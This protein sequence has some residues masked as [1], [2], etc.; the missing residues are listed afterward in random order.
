[1]SKL[2]QPASAGAAGGDV[3]VAEAARILKVLAE[4]NRVRLVRTLTLEC[5][6]VSEIVDEVGLSQPLVSHHLR[7]LRDAGIARQDR[8]GSFVYY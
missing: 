2:R 8:R 1:M 5:R 4:P 6:S 7:I 3:P